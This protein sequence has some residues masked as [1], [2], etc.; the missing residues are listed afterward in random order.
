MW[1]QLGQL[2]EQE[3][4]IEG[5]IAAYQKAIAIHPNLAFNLPEILRALNSPTVAQLEQEDRLVH[6]SL[7][8]EKALKLNRLVAIVFYGRSGS[9]F[10]QSLLDS[11]PSIATTP[12][13]YLIG[14]YEFWDA[15]GHLP[16]Q[17]LIAGFVECYYQLF[18]PRLPG[19]PP[20]GSPGEPSG[21]TKMGL[22]RNQSLGIDKATFIQ[23]LTEILSEQ[24]PIS[25]KFFFQAV[26]I[27]Y[28]ECL[29]R[30]ATGID[31]HII[32]F[33][34][35]VPESSKV[36]KI[37]SDFPDSLFLHVVRYPVQSLGSH[38][39]HHADPNG[40]NYALDLTLASRLIEH[41]L[42]DGVPMLPQYKDRSRAIKL[43]DLHRKPRETLEKLCTWLG[44]AWNDILLKST[45]DGIQ[46]WN[47]QN[48]PQIS[49]FSEVTI[50]KQHKE[51][52]TSFDKFRLN[53]LLSKKCR[54]WNYDIPQWYGWIF[55]KILIFILLIIPF[56]M[57]L[58][59]FFD[60]PIKNTLKVHVQGIFESFIE[61]R[62]ML[63]RAWRHTFKSQENELDLL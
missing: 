63:W 2:L 8:R 62:K 9:M 36:E 42:F 59:S 52:L 53:V 31:P 17:E 38:F 50:A 47:V 26:H 3:N 20:F 39:A 16:V 29:E 54:L 13:N 37:V 49:G 61:C 1:W 24:N 60:S 11:H 35:H 56:K 57:E 46:W 40:G 45:F 43:E 32:L 30:P 7:L 27:A 41:I 14:F 5:A 28:Q 4:R 25:R 19:W 55:A 34:M 44:I 10:M 33:S 22:E 51:Y 58:I 48:S 12:G 23:H 6:T 21:F 15:Y 18:D